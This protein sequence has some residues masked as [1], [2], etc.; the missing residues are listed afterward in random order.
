MLMVVCCYC[1]ERQTYQLEILAWDTLYLCTILLSRVYFL[2]VRWSCFF[3]KHNRSSWYSIFLRL[4]IQSSMWH[5]V[6]YPDSAVGK[7]VLFHIYCIL[8]FCHFWS[9]LA[10]VSELKTSRACALLS[11]FSDLTFLPIFSP[12]KYCSTLSG[13][14]CNGS[15]AC[16]KFSCAYIG[17]LSKTT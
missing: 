10:S 9:F 12:V 11:F 8:F 1:L 17:H 5:A 13:R 14:T 6:F 2:I 3:Y 16:R 4:G 7:G 15:L